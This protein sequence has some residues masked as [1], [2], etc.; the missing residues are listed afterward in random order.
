VETTAILNSALHSFGTAMSLEYRR[1][2]QKQ[3]PKR[4][5]QDMRHSARSEKK[6]RAKRAQKGCHHEPC[7]FY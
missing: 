1:S 3:L 2:Q 5:L 7:L 4:G 6:A